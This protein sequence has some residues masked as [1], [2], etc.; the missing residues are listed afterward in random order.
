MIMTTHNIREIP[1]FAY[2]IR[3]TGKKLQLPHTKGFSYKTLDLDGKNM[4]FSVKVKF[5]PHSE[6]KEDFF[7]H[8]HGKKGINM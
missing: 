4:A 6:G 2:A 7:E 8:F 5:L 1:L 3:V